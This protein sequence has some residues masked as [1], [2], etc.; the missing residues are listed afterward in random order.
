M[1]LQEIEDLSAAVFLGAGA[2]I[3]SG[4]P[5]GDAAAVEIALGL[6][7]ASGMDVD[8]FLL[9]TGATSPKASWPRIEVVLAALCEPIPDAPHRI[10][11]SFLG[12]R[13]SLTHRLLAELSPSPR[14]WLTTNFDDLLE[15]A[16]RERDYPVNVVRSR[17]EMSQLT[18]NDLRA[19]HVVVKLHG[20]A[21]FKLADED[22][23]AT[24][25]QILRQFP[26]SAARP[27]IQLA[28]RR[29]LVVIGYAARDPDLTE[30]VDALIDGATSVAWIGFREAPPSV[31]RLTDRHGDKCRYVPEGAPAGLVGPTSREPIE[32]LDPSLWLS[33]IRSVLMSIE[34]ARALD[35]VANV[36]LDRGDEGSLR[37]AILMQ[38]R[39]KQSTSIDVYRSLRRELV[40]ATRLPGVDRAFTKDVASRLI[41]GARGWLSCEPNLGVE[42]AITLAQTGL[43]YVK[44]EEL[45]CLLQDAQRVVPGL[46][47]VRLSTKLLGEVGRMKVFR[48]GDDFEEGLRDL[49]RAR[50]EARRLM[51]PLIELQ[52]AEYLAIGLMRADRAREAEAVL[53]S[54]R[55]TLDEVGLPERTMFW[56]LNMGEALRIQFRFEEAEAVNVELLRR[57]TDA[58]NDYV[59]SKASSNLGLCCVCL[60]RVA[61]ADA[62][63]VET[64]RIADCHGALEDAANATLNRGW[65][66]MVLRLWHE[67]IL[68]FRDATERYRE[69]GSRRAGAALAY[70]AWCELQLGEH[71]CCRRTL[72]GIRQD[73]E[74]PPGLFQ[75]DLAL[76]ENCLAWVGSSAA[77]RSKMIEAAITEIEDDAERS[78]KQLEWMLMQSESDKEVRIVATWAVVAALKSNLRPYEAACYDLVQQ[79]GLDL[80]PRERKVLDTL[81]HEARVPELQMGLRGDAH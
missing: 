58:G 2:S 57:A 27:L 49:E 61:E 5:L 14:L 65:L 16:L 34:P 70:L 13:P 21:V 73:N 1:V 32:L 39:R 74:I 36:L 79:R 11:S 28:A 17:P 19:A 18:E 48:G 30:F 26:A 4:L 42:A 29:P 53:V 77:E 3:G 25:E 72:A 78:Y 76:V 64:I 68:F 56:M 47:D 45:A 40:A 69:L 75:K 52:L 35:A 33:K 23:G 50:S 46:E 37:T 41:E 38:R 12:L 81:W 55:P 6:V 15:S 54:I 80:S 62:A 67:A 31:Q 10:L 59:R 8:Q 22:L 66:R 7:R 43:Q 71:A 24:I 60:A 44:F 63:F 9:D 51:A 20:D